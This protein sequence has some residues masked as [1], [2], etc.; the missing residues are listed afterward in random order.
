MCRM[1]LPHSPDESATGGSSSPGRVYRSSYDPATGLV[2]GAVDARG[3]AVRFDDHADLSILGGD[4]WKWL[5][6]GP[7]SGP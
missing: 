6:V 5:L 2:S 3:H 1:L 7:V 4:A